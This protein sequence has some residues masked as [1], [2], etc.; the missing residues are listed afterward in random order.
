M[1]DILVVLVVG[2]DFGLMINVGDWM[3][4]FFGDIFGECDFELIGGQGGFW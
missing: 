3:F 2:M 4:F 1:N